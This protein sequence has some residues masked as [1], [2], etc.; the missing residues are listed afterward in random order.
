MFK[1]DDKAEGDNRPNAKG[2]CKVAGT[3]YFVSA[4]TRTSQSGVKYQSLAF[5]PVNEGGGKPR[6]EAEP[7]VSS[8]RREGLTGG[9]ASDARDRLDPDDD[10]PF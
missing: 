10:L 6:F 9:R 2:R 5:Q 7:S 4:W 8:L 1:N 3:E